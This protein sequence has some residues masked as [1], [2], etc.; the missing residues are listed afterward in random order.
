MF[1]MD[2]SMKPSQ[3]SIPDL[4]YPAEVMGWG[5]FPRSLSRVLPIFSSPEAGRALQARSGLSLLGRGQGRA[6]A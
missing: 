6:S 2:Y 5:R 1:R 3:K 4:G